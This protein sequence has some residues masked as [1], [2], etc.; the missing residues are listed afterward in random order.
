MGRPVTG[1][2]AGEPRRGSELH[3]PFCRSAELSDIVS[4]IRAEDCRAVFLT[5]DSGLGASTI[6]R[7]LAEDA[8]EFVPVLAVHGSQSLAKIPYGVLA[9]HIGGMESPVEAFRL[10]VLRE[11]LQEIDRLRAE[12]AARG[13]L[14]TDLPLLIIDDAH[15]IDGATAEL[16]V[17]LVMA[18]SVNVVASHSSRHQLPAPLPKLWAAGLAENIDLLALSRDQ[19]HEFCESMLG[20]PVLPATSWH[21]WSMAAGN[22]LFLHLV[23]AEAMDQGLLAQQNGMWVG[24]H[25]AKVRSYGLEEAVRA[26]LRGLSAGGQAA[27]NLV[28]LSEP[29]AEA[30]LRALVDARDV[31]ELLDWPL[32][33]PLTSSPELLVLA[34]PLYGQV[35]RQM[36]PLAKSRQLHEQLMARFGEGEADGAGSKEAL[37]RRAV[38]AVEVGVEVPDPALLQAAVLACKMFQSTTALELA[39]H[40]KGQAFLLRANMVRARA[41]Y[42]MGDYQ[43]AFLLLESLRDNATGLEDLLFGALLHASTRSALG[44]PV[45]TLLA[46]ARELR[47]AGR[48]L[49]AAE[50]PHAESIRARCDSTALMVELMADSREGKYAD[51]TALA[52]LLNAQHGLS[53]AAEKLNRTMALAMDSERLTAQGFPEQGSLRAAE[54]FAIEHAEENDVFFLPENILLRQLAALLC[55]GNW[56]AVAEAMD[57]YFFE[58][59]P[60]VYSFGGS[61]NV[62]RGMVLLRAGRHAEALAELQ[63]GLESLRLSNPQQLLGYCTAMSAYAAARLGLHEQAAQLIAGHMESTGMHV[64]LAHERAYIAAARH[65]VDPDSGGLAELF[66]QADD[67]RGDGAAM[68][69]LNALSLAMELGDNS[70]AERVAA[71]AAGV[72]GP[73]ARGIGVYANALQGRDGDAL[74]H[75]AEVLTDAGLL[76]FAHL[77]LA[78]S[79]KLLGGTDSRR[80]ELNVRK[81]LRRLAA[82]VGPAARPDAGRAAA[83]LTRREREVATLAATGLTDREIADELTLAL[84]TV[85]G[86]LYR[87]YTKLGISAR[88][89]LSR[90]L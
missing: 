59:G 56:A 5:S 43:G 46:D 31:Q 47:E 42:N 55:A 18:G 65:L 78:R 68:L 15:F 25:T 66:S 30:D 2:L 82:S 8:G 72:E 88:E 71:V 7:I 24:E 74:A 80:Q 33:A 62:V 22:P 51:M 38:W 17:S 45:A 84:R 29:L 61:A 75:A 77:A 10:G 16:V 54:A 89:E 13:S 19:G 39:G 79:A 12:L 34:N 9:P 41:K 36:V 21:Y 28:A 58:A 67:A 50:P 86:H 90:A 76:G 60:V 20:G 69:E 85:E 6:L 3:S 32:I 64:V 44:M 57:V 11:I 70:V 48:R 37:L 49:A 63:G 53:T 35:I 81:E 4:A 26:A 52:E 87:T 14:S 23:V 83:A 27:L 73:W 1:F 40:I